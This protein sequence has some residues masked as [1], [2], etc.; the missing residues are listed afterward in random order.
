MATS[1]VSCR[2]RTTTWNPFGS[3]KS[4]GGAAPAPGPAIQSERANRADRHVLTIL[5]F[6]EIMALHYITRP[7]ASPEFRRL[8]GK[9][10]PVRLGNPVATSCVRTRAS[11][12]AGIL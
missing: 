3:A 1:R 2:S 6:A 9:I 8:A 5:D 10:L 12:H 7:S 4:A 11:I